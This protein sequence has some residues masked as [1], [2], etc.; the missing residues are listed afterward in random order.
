VGV[1]D[2][3]HL[4]AVEPSDQILAVVAPTAHQNVHQSFAYLGRD[5]LRY[6]DGFPQLLPDA[7]LMAAHHLSAV[8][9]TARL[10]HGGETDD[11]LH[12]GG[13]TDDRPDPAGGQ[14]VLRLYAAVTDAHHL[15][16][17]VPTARLHHGGETD[18]HLLAAVVDPSSHLRGAD[19]VDH[20]W[21]CPRIF[22]DRLDAVRHFESL[23]PVVH[24]CEAPDRDV[25]DLGAF[26]TG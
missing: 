22:G 10:H 17:V 1:P 13:D 25:R 24:P 18:D 8:V 7:V 2:D 6:G 23:R 16:A 19:D 4:D 26:A 9:P 3:H 11:H 5:H 12:H 20:C 21:D 14:N 15:S